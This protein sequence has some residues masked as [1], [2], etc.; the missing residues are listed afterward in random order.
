MIRHA[1]VLIVLLLGAATEDI[2][3]DDVVTMGDETLDAEG[4][5]ARPMCLPTCRSRAYIS[6]NVMKQ[7]GC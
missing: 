5:E 7:S 3:N 1:A 6:K 4:E 2:M